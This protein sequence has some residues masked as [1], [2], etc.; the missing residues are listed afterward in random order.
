MIAFDTN[1]LVYAQEQSADPRH[2][3]AIDL[4]FEASICGAIM[5]V[6]VLGEFLNVATRKLAMVPADAINQ[7]EEYCRLFTCP[8]TLPEDLGEAARLSSAHEL[9]FFD[10]LILSA[11]ARMGATLLLSED[12]HDGLEIGTI[13]VLN[14]FNPANRAEIATMLAQ[15]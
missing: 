5:P 14:P 4:L 7:V 1:I 11:A 13:R 6:Q 2:R 10:A 3:L 12:M 8:T 15:S 9:Q